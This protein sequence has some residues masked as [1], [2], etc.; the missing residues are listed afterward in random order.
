MRKIIPSCSNSALVGTYIDKVKNFCDH[1]I[2]LRGMTDNLLTT[3]HF[4][5]TS[6]SFRVKLYFWAL[7]NRT[8]DV[9]VLNRGIWLGGSAKN[10]DHGYTPGQ[11][12]FILYSNVLKIPDKVCSTLLNSRLSSWFNLGNCSQNFGNIYEPQWKFQFQGSFWQPHIW[13]SLWFI[14]IF[15][16]Q[17]TNRLNC[18]SSLHSTIQWGGTDLMYCR[19]Y[20]RAQVISAVQLLKC[21]FCKKSFIMNTPLVSCAY[22]SSLLGGYNSKPT[23]KWWQ[24]CSTDY[25]HLSN[26]REVTLTDFEKF[27]PPQ[28]N[29]PPRLLISLQN[30]LIFLQ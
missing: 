14:N 25:S 7:K 8:I 21:G 28:K 1:S 16:I 19:W 3:G 18:W 6:A 24:I 23:Q 2:T 22:L 30:F 4:W 26:K 15:E 11:I 12:V 27:H 13:H 9:L 20:F 29:P 10:C 5:T 17:A